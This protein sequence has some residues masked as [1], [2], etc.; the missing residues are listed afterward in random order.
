MFKQFFILALVSSIAA[1]IACVIY[2]N[3]YYSI[4]VDFSEAFSLVK[5]MANCALVGFGIAII[6]FGLRSVIK[7]FTV[8]DILAN[9]ILAIGSIAMVF[10][11]LVSEDP[12]FQ[13]ED[14]Q[15]MVDYY[16]GFV[17][18]MLFFPAL[19]YFLFKPLANKK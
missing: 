16:K 13:N 6:N 19:A 9:A 11:V 3:F 10:V 15:F 2:T 12:T 14:A 8:A 17:M 18:P 7:N 5:L 1:T 4:L